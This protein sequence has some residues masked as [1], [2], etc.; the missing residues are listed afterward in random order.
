MNTLIKTLNPL[1]KA[2]RLLMILN[3]WRDGNQVLSNNRRAL[4]KMMKLQKL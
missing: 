1:T 3:K 4:I 2:K